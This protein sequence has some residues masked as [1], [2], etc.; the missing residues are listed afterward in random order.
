MT[1][2]IIL[3]R[4]HVMFASSS[5]CWATYSIRVYFLLHFFS[6]WVRL[7]Y[8][9]LDFYFF[10]TLKW[11]LS[12]LT[13]MVFKAI[14]NQ[15]FEPLIRIYETHLQIKYSSFISITE[16]VNDSYVFYTKCIYFL[17]TLC[18][19]VYFFSMLFCSLCHLTNLLFSPINNIITF[20]YVPE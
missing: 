19:H 2:L 18:L 13:W 15:T 16:I 6:S 10:L 20:N 17:N 7:Y 3:W 4:Q 11:L 9:P 14:L 12:W 8:Y 1:W 5:R